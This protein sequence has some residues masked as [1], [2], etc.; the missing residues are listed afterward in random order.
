[1]K[2]TAPTRRMM[3]LFLFFSAL[4][5][6]LFLTATP[7]QAKSKHT[8]DTPSIQS[9]KQTAAT[10]ASVKWSKV[11]GADSYVVYRSTSKNGTYKKVKTITNGKTVSYTNSGLS[12]GK[13]YHFKV[14]ACRKVEGKNYYSAYSS[15]K[16]RSMTAFGYKGESYKS[17]CQRIFGT[18]SY[19]RYAS[20]KA[21]SKDM[22]TVSVKV[23]DL[24]SSG[25]K[26]SKTM[27]FKI[28]KKIA[29]TV[30]QIFAEIYNGKEKFPIHDLGGYSWRGNS[31]SSE[32]NQGLAIDINANENAMIRKSDGKVLAGKFYKPGKNPYSIPAGGDVVKAFEKYGFDWGDWSKT[33]DYMHFSY[34]GL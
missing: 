12:S 16:S 34:F 24:N 19:K 23:W 21:A 13:T 26:Y 32:H 2:T 4:F 8:P 33:V 25:K 6:T 22:T 17:K 3:P 5:L 7:A 20:S 31:S 14:K 9:V 28:H 15:S 27:S 10:K 1:M 29:P 30:K 11:S 18:N